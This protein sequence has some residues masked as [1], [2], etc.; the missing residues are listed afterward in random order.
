[1]TTRGDTK[2][3]K[4]KKNRKRKRITKKANYND[5]NNICDCKS[6]ISEYY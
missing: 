4:T 3:Q 6:G 2:K 1:M 5:Y